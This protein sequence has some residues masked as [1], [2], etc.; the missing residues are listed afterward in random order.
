[1]ASLAI[2]TKAIAPDAVWAALWHP[3]GTEDDIVVNALRVPRTVLGLLVGLA[4]GVAGA[5][6]QGLTRNPLADPGLLGVNAGAAF[7]VVLGH[8]RRSASARRRL[9][10]VRLAGAASRPSSSTRSARSAAAAPPR[11][12]WRSPAPPSR[13]LPRRA[14]VRARAA[15]R[16]SPRRVPVLAG[17]LARRPRR[18]RRSAGA[19]VPRRRPRPGAAQRARGL[20]A[21]ALGDDVARGLGAEHRPAARRVGVGRDHPALRRGHRRLRARS[22]SSAS[23]CRTSP[24]RS[25]A[26]TTGGCCPYSGAARRRAAA[27]GRRRRPGR[28]PAGRAA[29]SGS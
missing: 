18:R 11:S 17:R 9:R 22:P 20:N 10:L 28:R 8:R 25:S 24:A 1:M 13:A 16:G 15:R 21:L 5:L 26:P 23:S 4:L 2:G 14:D 29:R 12:R 3:A 19:A 27:R 7:A 6:M